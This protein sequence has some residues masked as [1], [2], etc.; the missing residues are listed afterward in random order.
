[1]R[2]LVAAALLVAACSKPS[3]SSKDDGP[4][5]EVVVDNMMAV[6]KTAMPPGHDGMALQNRK[7]MIDECVAR[8]MTAAQR[9][10]LAAAKDL[11]GLSACAGPRG[12]RRP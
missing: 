3:K 4:S 9:A 7:Q 8:A 11:S 12:T 1:M 2:Y 10:C 6:T 5:C